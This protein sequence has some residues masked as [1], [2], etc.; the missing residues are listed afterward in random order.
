MMLWLILPI[1]LIM[2]AFLEIGILLSYDDSMR[3]WFLVGK[4]R[5]SL[6]LKDEER[7]QSTVQGSAK[8]KKK[9]KKNLKP[10]LKAVLQNWIEILETIGNTLA[11]PTLE[12][13]ELQVFVGG[14]DPEGSAM[15]YGRIC[16]VVGC[17][18]PI[19]ENTFTVKKRL[20]DIRCSFEKD[21]IEF[22]AEAAATLKIYEL[23][24]LAVSILKLFYRI[25]S[26][27]KS[28]YESGANL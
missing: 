11:A 23:V 17:V 28:Y 6:S 9:R 18:L 16:S 12:K 10:W 14:Q 3:L 15:N 26:D 2:I 19:V 13:L 7:E 22:K 27:M 25:R 24:T 4:L 5:F 1:V 20:I 8:S 21:H